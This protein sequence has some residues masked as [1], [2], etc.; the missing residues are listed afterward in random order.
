MTA[1]GSA[2]S[3]PEESPGKTG[4]NDKI[5]MGLIGCGGQ[6]RGV[7]RELSEFDDVEFIA[8]CDVD[9]GRMLEAAGE[10]EGRYGRKPYACNDFR[11]LLGIRE[12]DAVVVGTP[13]HWHALPTIYACEAGKDVYLEKP[14]AHDITEGQ[15][16]VRAAKKYNRVIQVG[17]WQRSIQHFVDVIDYVRSGGLGQISVCR[18][19]TLGNGAIG[20]YPVT[21]PPPD[22]DWD[23]WVGPAEWEPY[24]AGRHPYNFRWFFNYAAGLTGDWGVHMMDIVLLGMDV[25]SPQHVASYGGKIVAGEEDDRTTPDTQMAIY[26]FPEFVMNWEIHVGAPALDGGGS[27]GAEFI[28]REGSI[29]VDRGGYRLRDGRG[30]PVEEKLPTVNPLPTNHMR[31]FVDCI[32]TR[33]KPRSDIETMHKTTTLC[34]LANLTYLIGRSVEWDGEKDMVVGDPAAMDCQSYRR[35]YRRPWSLPMHKV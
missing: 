23:F 26:R 35:E 4:P 30:N 32:K 18:A 33:K 9:R 31:N 7:M 11:D 16:I 19:W 1:A 17:T 28:G 13:D 3:A 14:I 5:L 34:H 20:Q 24:R 10:V 12:I 22:L 6:G 29:I 27:H 25:W 8:V 2:F 15:A 21:E